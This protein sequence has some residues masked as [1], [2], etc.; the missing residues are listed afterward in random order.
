MKPSTQAPISRIATMR[1]MPAVTSP[2]S[3][4]STLTLIGGHTALPSSAMLFA[5]APSAWTREAAAVTSAA[6]S[7]LLSPAAGPLTLAM[8]PGCA[9]WSACSLK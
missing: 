5:G 4:H 7:R 8:T 1:A 2:S 6:T 3:L 9:S